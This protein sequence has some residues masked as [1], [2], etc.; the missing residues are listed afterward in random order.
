MLHTLA[1]H[2]ARDGEV[3]GFAGDLVDLIDVD[4][5]HL[6]SIDVVIGGGDELEQDV[7][8]VLAHVSGLGERRRVGDGK[9][10]VEYASERLGQKRLAAA[11]GA[12]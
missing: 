9:G 6:R 8:D 12:E 1:R 2:V 3:F 5:A 10:D 11:R 4:D 7:L